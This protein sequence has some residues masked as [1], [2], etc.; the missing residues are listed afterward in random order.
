MKKQEVLKKVFY[1][2]AGFAAPF[3][4]KV[5][6]AVIKVRMDEYNRKKC[7]GFVPEEI[8]EAICRES[9]ELAHAADDQMYGMG[10][11]NNVH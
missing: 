10:M 1:Q 4:G 11:L 2:A 7:A 9:T 6:D 5:R 3:E 8:A